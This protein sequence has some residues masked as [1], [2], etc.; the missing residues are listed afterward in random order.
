MKIIYI[1][2]AF[3]LTALFFM[4][5]KYAADLL[6]RIAGGAALLIIFNSVCGFFAFHTVGINIL[7]S[8]VV[9]MLGLPGGVVLVCLSLFL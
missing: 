8:A 5:I 9:G 4:N 3:L 7:S 1:I 6:C 2:L